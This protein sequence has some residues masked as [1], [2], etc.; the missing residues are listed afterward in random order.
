[1]HFQE[2]NLACPGGQ[3]SR[4]NQA[5]SD[6]PGSRGYV[7]KVIEEAADGAEGGDQGCSP[8]ISP[9]SPATP[10]DSPRSHAGI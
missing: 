2:F 9:R 4:K 1:M 6:L 3:V 8:A 5:F 10:A 7:Y